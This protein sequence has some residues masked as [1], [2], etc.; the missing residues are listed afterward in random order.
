MCRIECKILTTYKKKETNV[1]IG[2]SKTRHILY[3][4]FAQEH[5]IQLTDN[6]EWKAQNLQGKWR[7][8]KPNELKFH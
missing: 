6:C 1:P 7:K 8:S 5:L 2:W 4:K 3:F